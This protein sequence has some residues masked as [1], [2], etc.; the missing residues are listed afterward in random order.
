MSLDQTELSIEDNISNEK[1]STCHS[2]TT[3]HSAEKAKITL[4]LK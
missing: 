2:D 4:L 1:N 3:E